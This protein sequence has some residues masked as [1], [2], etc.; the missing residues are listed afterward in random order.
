MEV[1]FRRLHWLPWIFVMTFVLSVMI[2]FAWSVLLGDVPVFLP[3]VSDT[4]GH[5]PQSALFGLALMICAFCAV[6]SFVVRFYSV[7]AA[8]SEKPRN[9]VTVMNYL[10]IFNAGLLCLGMLM[11]STNPVS[12]LRRDGT[13]KLPVL[14][15]HLVGAGILFLNA[16]A[17]FII[18]TCFVW[19]LGRKYQNT[20]LGYARTA[21]NLICFVGAIALVVFA[22]YNDLDGLRPVPEHGTLYKGNS[23]WSAFGEW[24][25]ILGF[26]CNIL[27]LVP[28]LRRVRV[29]L[30]VEN[31]QEVA[32]KESG[33]EVMKL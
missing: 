2:V 5:A 10:S 24:I 20:Y 28:D 15:P 11:V 26:L 29:S 16:G 1:K 9:V 33:N 23:P 22:P 19:M 30:H 27:S 12:H 8:N 21:S 17:Y 32:Q 14:A 7:K 25:M 18:Q 13:W 6:T 31:I 3:Y 4:G